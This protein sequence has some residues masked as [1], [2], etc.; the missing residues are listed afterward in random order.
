MTA[1]QIE[2]LE[3]KIAELVSAIDAAGMDASPDEVLESVMDHLDQEI[4]EWEETGQ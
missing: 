2:R 4:E 3:S 1:R